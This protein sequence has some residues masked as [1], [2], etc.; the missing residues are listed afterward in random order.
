ML[1]LGLAS[2]KKFPIY[3]PQR[4]GHVAE[5]GR[6]ANQSFVALGRLLR[7][8]WHFEMFRVNPVAGKD[9]K[10]TSKAFSKRFL[11]PGRCR[12]PGTKAPKG[13][14]TCPDLWWYARVPGPILPGRA[15]RLYLEDGS[16]VATMVSA[17]QRSAV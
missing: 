15:D 13:R 11:G 9:G 10:R 7:Q 17:T 8:M 5:G 4:Q 14:V 12:R 6:D 1:D 2:I 16:D 3:F